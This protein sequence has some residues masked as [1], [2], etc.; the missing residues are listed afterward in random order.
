[1]RPVAHSIHNTPF[2]TSMRNVAAFSVM[3]YAC[4]VASTISSN[5]E[6]FVFYFFNYQ[7]KQEEEEEEKCW[8]LMSKY[9]VAG[10][11][12]F[13]LGPVV[14]IY[15]CRLAYDCIRNMSI[16]LRKHMYLKL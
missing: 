13:F 7:E 6:P 4:C 3:F 14:M 10:L 2:Q 12:F 5:A 9:L 15:Y 1:M 11:M 16:K 8:N